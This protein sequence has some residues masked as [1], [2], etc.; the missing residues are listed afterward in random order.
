MPEGLS[1]LPLGEAREIL[2]PQTNPGDVA[3]DEF[4]IKVNKVM[5]RIYTMGG[6]RGSKATY[7]MNVSS[8]GRVTL[9]AHLDSIIG[10]QHDLN[11]TDDTAGNVGLLIG[12]MGYE[13]LYNGP[14]HLDETQATSGELIDE[15]EVPTLVEFPST[16]SQLT[17]TISDSGDAGEAIKITGLD[18]SSNEVIDGNGA[19][20]ERIVYVNPDATSSTTY[21]DIYGIQKD[22]TQGRVIVKHGSTVLATLQP[23]ERHPV[24]RRYKV[25]HSDVTDA[26]IKAYCKRRYV[27]VVDEE[28]YIIPGNLAALQSG[29][30]ALRKHE[31]GMIGDAE[32]YWQDAIRLLSGDQTEYNGGAVR[33]P[34]YHPWG[35][36]QKSIQ[37]GL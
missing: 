6:W 36:G 19:P 10:Y 1:A 2:A 35:L 18:D 13:F 31:E 26:T 16:A 28:D 7:T 33:I 22:L 34:T 29:L 4:R 27:P 14:G 8:T 3:S 17:V 9:P 12:G 15:G 25:A 11:S 20:G 24:Y 37:H 23:G 5:S 30:L 32:P 21:S